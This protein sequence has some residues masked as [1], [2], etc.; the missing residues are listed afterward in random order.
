MLKVKKLDYEKVFNNPQ[1]V[2]G[3]QIDKNLIKEWQNR[4]S[5]S[6]EYSNEQS[7]VSKTFQEDEFQ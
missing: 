6:D 2:I 4:D 1:N 3:G 7:N 5:D